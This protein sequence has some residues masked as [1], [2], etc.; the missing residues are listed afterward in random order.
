M[1]ERYNRAL[2]DDLLESN[3][4]ASSFIQILTEE[5]KEL[6][7]NLIQAI[8]SEKTAVQN[9]LRTHREFQ[10]AMSNRTPA[11]AI[12]WLDDKLFDMAKLLNSLLDKLKDKR[13]KLDEAEQ[14]V[15]TI[16]KWPR[17]GTLPWELEAHAAFSRLECLIEAQKVKR[18]TAF[19]LNSKYVEIK[20][21][22]L[23]EKGKYTSILKNMEMGLRT[24]KNELNSL[25]TMLD[26][27]IYF[28]NEAYK[29]LT[30]TEKESSE[31]R[32]RR[33]IQMSKMKKAVERILEENQQ[34]IP[35]NKGNASKLT[36][37]KIHASFSLP[38]GHSLSEVA[39]LLRVKRSEV[40]EFQARARKL[41]ETMR[42]PD[43]THIP[44][45]LKTVSRIGQRLE[46][47]LETK[48]KL[49]DLYVQQRSQLQLILYYYRYTGVQQ[50]ED[51]QAFQEEYEKSIS[52]AV[53]RQ[54]EVV[55]KLDRVGQI[56]EELRL[57]ILSLLDL[58]N[59]ERRKARTHHQQRDDMMTS[60]KQI[61]DKIKKLLG[62]INALQSLFRRPPVRN[63]GPFVK[64]TALPNRLVRVGTPHQS[65]ESDGEDEYVDSKVPT[66]VEI[67]AKSARFLN[68]AL[69]QRGIH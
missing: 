65:D 11:V 30:L 51:F 24:L 53:I 64:S 42:V 33:R 13:K 44:V 31:N 55:R 69:L 26:D 15:I 4:G 8:G 43:L 47:E 54:K 7:Q 68:Q 66:R 61:I 35:A 62:Q 27:A 50:L 5:T 29:S 60:M 19:I 40:D 25:E 6:R 9:A 14:M 12:P 57:G 23:A 56:N 46:K 52:E 3:E 2:Q 34:H 37:K 28:R 63:Y 45:R 32:K 67:K 21:H 1:K 38:M 48:K 22:L 39:E 36:V 59:M 58:L 16:E 41:V 10:L 17:P 20:Y 18:E 49:R